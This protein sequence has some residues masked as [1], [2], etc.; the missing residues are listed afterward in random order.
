[1][2]DKD[3]Y[4]F[5]PED[6]DADGGLPDTETNPAPLVIIGCF[7][8]GLGFLV[9]DFFAESVAVYG[10]EV[11]L[12]GAATAMFAFGLIVGGGSYVQQGQVRLGIV[13]VA[14]ALGWLFLA[15]GRA[16]SSSIALAVGSLTLIAGAVALFALTWQSA[17]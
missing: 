1:M 15:L 14:G 7:G 8:V 17:G 12:T 13:H 3:E 5:Y 9:A 10:T 4:R 2:S 16:F 6:F 11:S